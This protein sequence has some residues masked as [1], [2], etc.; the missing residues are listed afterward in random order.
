MIDL[1]AT[2][3]EL[4]ID[5]VEGLMEIEKM[6]TINHLATARSGNVIGGGD[7]SP[8]RIVPDAICSLSNNKPI[9]VRN[10]KSRRPWQH[11]LEPLSGYLLLVEKIQDKKMKNIE[12]NWNFGPNISNCKSVK[13]IASF[14]ADSLRLKLKIKNNKD[15]GFKPE[16]SFLRLSN[17]KAK[18]FLKWSPEWNL[19]QSLQ[20]ILEWNM[21]VKKSKYIDV[22][23]EQILDFMKQ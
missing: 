9:R 10:P 11:V 6:A 13:Y 20:K 1:N 15:K 14:F 12:Q 17:Y 21:K 4:K 8:N 5:D 2:L 23:K 16:T 19:N 3:N 22:C 18:K 7:W